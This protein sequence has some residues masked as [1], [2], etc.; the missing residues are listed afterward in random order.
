MDTVCEQGTLHH[1]KQALHQLPKSVT[2]AFKASVEQIKRMAGVRNK[3]SGYLLARHVLTW[4]TH[5]RRPLTVDQL[6]HSYAV[7][8]DDTYFSADCLP[9]ELDLLS[10]C[11]G[12]VVVN[13]STR[14]VGLIHESA[15]AYV[16][17]HRLVYEQADLMMA[18]ICLRYLLFDGSTEGRECDRPLSQ[19]AA[20]YWMAHLGPEEEADAE[21]EDL[22]IRFLKDSAKVQTA[23]RSMTGST[24]PAFDGISGLHASVY[25]DRP[26]LIERLLDSEGL[27]VNAAAA[28]GQTAL[29]WAAHHGRSAAARVLT[30]RTAD[31]DRQDRHKDTPL[32]IALLSAGEVSE[33]VVQA[34]VDAR[35]RMDIPGQRGHTALGWAVKHATLSV[36][37]ILLRGLEDVNAE[38]T[39]GFPALREV[40]QER[41]GNELH[42][43]VDILLAKGTDPNWQ[44]TSTDWTPLKGAVE[45]EDPELVVQLLG[46]KARVNLRGHDSGYT[47][48][49]EGVCYS[50]QSMV[51]LLIEHGADV[52]DRFDDGSTPLTTAI[53]VDNEAIMRMLLQHGAPV[54]EKLINGSTPLIEA[55]KRNAPG[56]VWMLLESGAFPDERDDEGSTALHHATKRAKSAGG[57]S[58][59]LLLR[60]GP[61]VELRDNDR[62]SPLDWAVEMNDL[63]A[64]WLLC[65][66]GA[67]PDADD[68]VGGLTALCRASGLGHR[69]L[70]RFLLDRGATADRVDNAGHAALHHAAWKGHGEVV[71]LL[72][73]RGATVDSRDA[74]GKT[75]LVIAARTGALDM[76]RVL[77]QH[78]AS[79]DIGNTDG[80]NALHFAASY[81]F[82][83]GLRL[84]LEKT[85]DPNLPDRK[86]TAPLHWAAYHGDAET[87]RVLA[88]GGADIDARTNKTHMTPLML[89][90]MGRRN[91]VV[92]AL[93]EAK[94]K[95][96][97]R[98]TQ[99]VTAR[100]HAVRLGHD[101]IV[102]IL[103]GFA[104]GKT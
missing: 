25:L 68:D 36:A 45:R 49:R 100:E 88:A 47:A 6:R 10:V 75:A 63:S 102:K 22:A 82:N 99:G 65:E 4:V 73:S 5:A 61:N 64:A 95:M 38:I 58:L 1:V 77:L 103:D 89:A 98:D 9:D 85:T 3:R 79:T 43:L 46:K 92:L 57:A 62:L 37:K 50:R 78:G 84:L 28:D 24:C 74:E 80:M 48:L 40:M 44:S 17:D 31:P 12:L 23:F 27:D 26:R 7:Q 30:K 51:Q 34:L 72:A 91:D 15:E 35:P 66:H 86:G 97:L 104:A 29:H 90:V 81:K 71:E 2:T 21:A 54:N 76:L 83:D 59:W 96:E 16:R 41:G 60:T 52:K 55:V 69:E 20:S 32:H 39:P 56:L 67:D 70:V 33:D 53:S 14:T 19:Y 11:A 101:D 13:P 93:L 18:K 42:E 8:V 87:I 94:A